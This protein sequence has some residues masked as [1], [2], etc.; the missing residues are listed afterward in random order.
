MV[1]VVLEGRGW[2]RSLGAR[3]PFLI[4][5]SFRPGKSQIEEGG[6]TR[7]VASDPF[8]LLEEALWS[9][10]PGEVVAVGYLSYDFGLSLLSR[11]SGSSFPWPPPPDRAEEKGTAWALFWAEGAFAGTVF[12]VNGAEVAGDVF[13]ATDTEGEIDRRFARTVFRPNGGAEGGWERDRESFARLVEEAREHIGAGEVYV[14]N[15]SRRWEG[16]FAGNPARIYGRLRKLNPEPF[17]AYW[18]EEGFALALASPELFLRLR[19]RRVLTRPIKGTLPRE[20]DP[21]RLL[22][23]PK[24]R[25]ELLMVVDL[26]RNDLGRVCLP[27][28]VQVSKLYEVEPF[29]RVWHLVATVEG[30]LEPEAGLGELIMSVFPGGSVTGAPKVRACELIAGLEGRGRGLYTG[31]FGWLARGKGGLEGELAMVIR[32]LFFRPGRIFFYTGVGVTWDSCPEKEAEETE[33]KARGLWEAAGRP[34]LAPLGRRG[35]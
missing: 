19:G 16:S 34:L 21:G 6:R 11:P 17:R 4:I 7:S 15:L 20:E 27:G 3:D 28:T 26:E 25:A 10:R 29:S 12:R 9:F 5:R 35:S 32:T 13:R 22:A 31:A 18:E 30:V 23:D 24:E 8:K 14:I 2:R 33:W 1:R